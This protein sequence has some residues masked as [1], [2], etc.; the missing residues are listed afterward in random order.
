MQL[1][2]HP[3]IKAQI[4]RQLVRLVKE[5]ED[6]REMLPCT[7]LIHHA[8]EAVLLTVH[9]KPFLVVLLEML[10]LSKVLNNPYAVTWLDF[11]QEMYW[12]LHFFC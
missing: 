10:A 6:V 8:P 4:Q 12:H 3:L 1:R 9:F 11:V 2:F 7:I 5:D